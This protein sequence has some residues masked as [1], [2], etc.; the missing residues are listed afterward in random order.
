MTTP[1]A[2]PVQEDWSKRQSINDNIFVKKK[3]RDA[4]HHIFF[5]V[6]HAQCNRVARFV[7]TEKRHNRNVIDISLR[8]RYYSLDFLTMNRA[9][10]IDDVLSL[11]GFRTT[12]VGIATKARI[13]VVARA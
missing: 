2:I 9:I 4:S 3:E 1:K 6:I 7:A 8:E 12:A 5:A 10:L 13:L 11:A